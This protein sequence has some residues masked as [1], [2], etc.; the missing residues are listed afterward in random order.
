MKRQSRTSRPTGFTLLELVIA[1]GI[2]LV[3]VSLVGSFMYTELRGHQTIEDSLKL[4]RLA[5]Q[6]AQRLAAQKIKADTAG[7]ITIDYDG[8]IVAFGESKAETKR[9]VN[10]GPGRKNPGEMVYGY[11]VSVRAISGGI[12]H[13]DVFL[14]AGQGRDVFASATY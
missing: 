7:Q 12:T 4:N 9:P 2:L 8:N 6:V 13:V 3:T 10:P 11:T 5:T 1:I 14:N